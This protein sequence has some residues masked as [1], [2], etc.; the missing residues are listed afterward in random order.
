[1]K[2]KVV[3]TVTGLML[4]IAAAFAAAGPFRTAQAED[5]ITPLA[6][7]PVVRRSFAP[8]L[9]AFVTELVPPSVVTDIVDPGDGRLFIA[10]R[11]GRVQVASQDG[12]VQPQLLLDIRD[13]VYL[14]G[15]EM[16]LVGLAVHPDYASNKH[17]F[18]YYT[19]G[20][21][22]ETG[23]EQYFSVVAR[24][25]VDA[26]GVADPATEERILHFQLPTTRH[27]GG[28]MHF[29][30]LDGYLYIAVGDGGTGQDWQGY[31][32]SKATLLGKILRID[33]D[34]GSPYAIPPDNPF[35]SDEESRGEIWALG[36][37]NPWRISFDRQTGDLYIGDV[38]ESTWEEIDFIPAGSSGGENF[39]WPCMEGPAVFRPGVCDASVT[40]VAPIFAYQHELYAQCSVAAGF[41]YRGS[42]IP[43]L[44]GHFLLADFCSTNIWSLK[45]VEGQGWSV[46]DWGRYEHYFTTFG[47]RN[48][49]ELFLGAAS[50]TN[51]YQ[52]VGIDEGN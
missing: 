23:E 44:Y 5:E 24:Y 37:R 32:Q 48:D 4:I 40:Y 35:V 36:L 21:V 27:H 42:Q 39:G 13:R 31:A 17:I 47:E 18:A 8:Q 2:K 1:M 29:G 45:P 34:N 28:A 6:F 22:S 10:T 15:N 30:P 3:I 46:R 14:D 7:L 51:I 49:G 9:E 19:E 12:T 11:D 50:D 52:I 26:N 43:E 25:I 16:G 41:V 38:G 33:V 20:V